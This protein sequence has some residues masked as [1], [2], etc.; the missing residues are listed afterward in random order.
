MKHALAGSREAPV[1][2]VP[3]ARPT[4]AAGFAGRAAELTAFLAVDSG[5]GQQPAVP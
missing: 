5:Q 4:D 1:D 3:G 2:D